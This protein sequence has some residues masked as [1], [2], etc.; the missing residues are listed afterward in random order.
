[1]D[2]SAQDVVQKYLSSLRLAN[3]F[4]VEPDAERLSQDGKRPLVDFGP[5]FALSQYRGHDRVVLFLTPDQAGRAFSA[6]DSWEDFG[7]AL[8]IVI[9]P[10]AGPALPSLEKERRMAYA[11]WLLSSPSARPSAGNVRVFEFDPG[12]GT[13][14]FAFDL[15]DR[16]RPSLRMLPDK[17][18]L[19]SPADVNQ[20]PLA[21]LTAAH[22][23]WQGSVTLFGPQPD[24]AL[25]EEL[26]CRFLAR[27]VQNAGLTGPAF[28]WFQLDLGSLARWVA[29]GK[30][31]LRTAGESGWISSFSP[32]KLWAAIL[33][34]HAS[35][36]RRP[37]A[38]T[39]DLL[40]EES[41]AAEVTYLKG[42]LR[43]RKPTV[44]AHL[45]V[46]AAGLYIYEAAHQTHSSFIR[47][48]ALRDA[49]LAET[50]RVFYEHDVGEPG[51]RDDF[52]SFLSKYQLRQL[53]HARHSEL[54]AACP[55]ALVECFRAVL[56]GRNIWFARLVP[57]SKTE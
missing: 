13:F 41:S 19:I 11:K 26:T 39:V 10:A 29:R 31:P 30:S 24:D 16:R 38:H 7:G 40:C 57:D 9:D 47:E 48:K 52:T 56:W 23:F 46:T 18:A 32:L 4:V 17:L 33:E 54:R 50:A 43:L 42:L 15:P 37:A 49:L 44:P 25:V 6:I 45:Q 22:R 20:A 27:A 3:A 53:L 12:R 28:E 51:R 21:V 8:A 35:V 55:P 2:G 1:M 36:E 34:R 14:Q 5:P